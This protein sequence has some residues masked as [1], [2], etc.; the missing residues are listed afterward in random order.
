[1]YMYVLLICE[2]GLKGPAGITKEEKKN[3]GFFIKVIWFPSPQ[4]QLN[5][6]CIFCCTQ[7]ENVWNIVTLLVVTD[8]DWR[9][10]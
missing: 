1:M 2:Y 10:Y 4:S 7:L 5:I 6:F 8:L 3:I 9:D